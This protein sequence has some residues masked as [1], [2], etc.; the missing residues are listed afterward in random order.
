MTLNEF[1]QVHTPSDRLVVMDNAGNEIYRGFVACMRHENIDGSRKIKR[2][3]VGTEIFRR[4][5][6]SRFDYATPLGE[7]VKIENV[8]AFSFS[9]LALRVYTKVVLED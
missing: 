8:S 3:G 5:K 6:E 2:F 1:L 4:G 7:A 9:D